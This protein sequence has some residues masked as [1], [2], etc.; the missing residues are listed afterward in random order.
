MEFDEVVRRRHMVRRYL[1]DPVPDAT[2]S[3]LLDTARRGPSAG[4]S[5]GQSFVAV[6]DPGLRAQIATLC[7]EESYLARGFEPWISSAPVLVVVCTSRQAYAERYAEADKLGPGAEPSWPIPFWYVDAGCALM[8]LLLA[9]VDHGLAAGVLRVRDEDGLR[10]LLGIPEGEQPVAIVTVG[11]A[12]TD[13]RSGS[14]DR[15]R[16][17]FDEVVHRNGW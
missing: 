14:L 11:K 6:T 1:P 15:G 8:L 3:A 17:P 2:L 16:R 10:A 5:Q 12:A 9:A 4:Y 13:R 7:A